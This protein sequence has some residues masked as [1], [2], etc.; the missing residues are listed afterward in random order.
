MDDSCCRCSI[1]SLLARVS[2]PAATFAAV[3][4]SVEFDSACLSMRRFRKSCTSSCSLVILQSKF[5]HRVC[6]SSTWAFSRV[7]CAKLSVKLCKFP[8]ARESL[9]NCFSASLSCVISFTCCFSCAEAFSS[10]RRHSSGRT[11]PDLA[12]PASRP[13]TTAAIAFTHSI[14]SAWKAVR[15][16]SAADM[17]DAVKAAGGS[18]VPSALSACGPVRSG[19][20][21]SLR[22]HQAALSASSPSL[23]AVSVTR[24]GG[25]KP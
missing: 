5:V 11:L 9:R 23:P 2:C 14:A 1:S 6:C 25:G 12:M 8:D 19:V 22:S 24:T 7:S 20:E 13:S 17:T 3:E 15:Q 18:C 4:L 21:V 16:M 10:A